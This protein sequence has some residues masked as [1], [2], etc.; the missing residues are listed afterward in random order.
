MTKA[1]FA[2]KVVE[3]EK[4]AMDYISLETGEPLSNLFR[5]VVHDSV[6]DYLGKV[7]IYR[8]DLTNDPDRPANIT[9]AGDELPMQTIVRDFISIMGSK[10]D[11]FRK[12]FKKREFL[13]RGEYIYDIDMGSLAERVGERFL[14]LE[15]TFEIM[16]M[17]AV[18]SIIFEELLYQY[19]KLHAVGAMMDLEKE[20]ESNRPKIEKFRDGIVDDY[21]ARYEEEVVEV[22]TLEK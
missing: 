22:E 12:L 8:A 14:E 20:W 13:K 2:L 15:T 1:M 4:H 18:K 11:R 9:P 21:N 3:R 6:I 10:G 16:D 17:A 5:Q 7:L 19:F